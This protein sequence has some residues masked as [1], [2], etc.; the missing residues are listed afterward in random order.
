[1]VPRR[2]PKSHR[3]TMRASKCAP[4]K[5][6]HLTIS[7]KRP[8][9]PPRAK[10]KVTGFRDRGDLAL[11]ARCFLCRGGG[12]GFERRQFRLDCAGLLQAG[13]LVVERGG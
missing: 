11:L 1:M 5:A 2:D 6:F 7:N 13:N 12:G 4:C 8:Q 3:S 9:V 10:I